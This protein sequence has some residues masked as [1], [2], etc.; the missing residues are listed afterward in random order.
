VYK[1]MQAAGHQLA[2]HSFTHPKME[3]LPDYASIDWEYNEDVKA[4]KSQFN[5]YTTPYFR[6]P[7]GTEGARMRSRLVKAVGSKATITNWSVDVEDWLWAETNTPEQQKVAF[8]RDVNKGG[9][10]VV[11]HYLYPSTVSYLREFI[12]IAKKTGK[13]LMRVDQCMMD[14]SA[15]PL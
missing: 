4:M 14:P 8:Q 5:G 12:Q 7:F 9:N 13:Q 11:L 10:L 1:E 2:M 6:P 3:G 15:P